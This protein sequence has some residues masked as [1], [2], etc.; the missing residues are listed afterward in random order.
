MVYGAVDVQIFTSN[1]LGTFS[2]SVM[3]LFFNVVE[4]LVC[5]T[6]SIFN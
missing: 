5:Y 3:Y 4:I 1:Q 6:Y 2:L